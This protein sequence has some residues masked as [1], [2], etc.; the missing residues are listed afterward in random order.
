MSITDFGLF[1]F[2]VDVIRSF[3][4]KIITNFILIK[5]IVRASVQ[6]REQRGLAVYNI[7]KSAKEV[8]SFLHQQLSVVHPHGKIGI[9]RIFLLQVDQEGFVEHE[10]SGY[11]A[12][13]HDDPGL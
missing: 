8:H 9:L 2:G 3:C 4:Q 12:L 6:A 10:S 5:W 1:N 11:G 7:V 13:E